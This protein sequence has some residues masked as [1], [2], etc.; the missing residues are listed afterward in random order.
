MDNLDILN[1]TSFLNEDDLLNMHKEKG[2]AYFPI[3]DTSTSMQDKIDVVNNALKKQ[4]EILQEK[5]KEHKVAKVLVDILTFDA[6]A[7]WSYELPQPIKDVQFMNLDCHIGKASL[8]RP[9]Y[10]ALN[11]ALNENTFL[12]DALNYYPILILITD[13]DINDD[14]SNALENIKR[15][16]WFNKATKI[17]LPIC[18]GEID[19]LFYDTLLDFT[20]NEKNIIQVSDI[21]KL[22]EIIEIATRKSIPNNDMDDDDDDPFQSIREMF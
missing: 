1:D 6:Q 18:T 7:Q 21:D 16:N 4:F 11:E 20:D 15:N 2:C 19:G 3:V 14:Y 17:A 10:N 12:A 8:I 13:G 9:M 22:S 5:D